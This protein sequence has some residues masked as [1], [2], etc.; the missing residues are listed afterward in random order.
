MQLLV[1]GVSHRSTPL[2]LLERVAVPAGQCA[3]VLAELLHGGQLSEAVLLSTCSRVEVFA[4]ADTFHGAL[5]QISAVLAGRAGV[6]T[7][8]LNRCLR[9][10]HD[11][12][13]VRHALRVAA[14]LD[15]MVVGEPQILGQLR[16]AY[17]DAARH[18]AAGRLLHELMRHALQA[19]R[20]IRAQT[21]IDRAGR[22]TVSA[23]LELGQRRAGPAPLGSALV[24]GAGAMGALAVADLRRLGV[25]DIAVAN[26]DLSRAR[27]LAAAYAARALP[28]DQVPAA[29]PEADL[30]IC[31]TG[32]P[33][34]LLRARDFTG[35]GPKLVLDLALPRDVDPAAAGRP[36]VTLV[37]LS[38]LADTAGADGQ[39]AAERLIEQEVA[40][41]ETRLRHAAAGPTVAALRCRA[42]EVADVEL[43]ALAG[44]CP[45]MDG[46]QRAEVARTVHRIMQRLLHEP[47]VRV[48][49]MAAQPGG[50]RYVDALRDLFDL[51]VPPSAG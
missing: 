42:R 37:D 5:D 2:D 30:V 9:I 10:G 25:P 3:P 15:S 49:Q 32:S 16:R 41:F 43:A 46:P 8:E 27:R 17:A 35:G 50:E 33:G 1:V 20:R 28:L 14:G 26:R 18:G 45:G 7:E 40:E 34:Y 21:G 38:H 11:Q 13:A 24:I 31:A 29:L 22:S 44:R 23:A 36:G 51:A 39:A 6:S 47:S 48:R 19:G 12:E 4:T